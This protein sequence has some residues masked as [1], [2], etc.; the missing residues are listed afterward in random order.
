MANEMFGRVP[1][2]LRILPTIGSMESGTRIYRFSVLLLTFFAYALFHASRKPPSIVKNVLSS[3]GSLDSHMGLTTRS[4]AIWPLN[5]VYLRRVQSNFTEIEA[6]LSSGWAPF[7]GDSGTA[8]LADVDVAFLVSYSIGMY[9]AGHLGDRIDLRWFLSGGMVGSGIFVSLFGLAYWWN[10]H[11]IGY[12]FMVQI[13]GGFIQASGWPSVVTIVGNWFGKS[14]RGLIMGVWNS[15]TS[16]GNIWGTLMAS[17]VLKYGWGWSFLIPGFAIIGGGIVMFLFLVVDPKIVGLASPY[18]TK[19]GHASNEED[20][21]NGLLQMGSKDHQV[22]LLTEDMKLEDSEE[23]CETAVAFLEAW[24]IPG[25]ARFAICL[26]FTK[27]VAYTFLYWLP[28]YIKHTEIN[29]EYLSDSTS[30]NLSTVFDVGGTLGGIMAGYMS[31]KLNARATVAASFTYA[32]VPM[33]LLY[34]MYGGA[35]YWLN[36]LLLFLTGLCVNGPYA[37]ITTAV[38]AD[39]G[40]HNS[41]KGSSKALATVTAIIDGTGSIGAA[42]GPFVTGYISKSGWN[43]VFIM[44]IVS[45]TISGLLITGLVIEELKELFSQWRLSILWHKELS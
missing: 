24:T 23:D 29:G 5:I 13:L 22:P 25:V 45:A 12:F 31:D 15:H 34:R 3:D 37:L 33:L 9:F 19:Q 8:L 18:D 32:A 21:E 40:T 41:L 28:F 2:G 4:T 44:L 43:S 38:A 1:P 27:L 20:E 6:T 30:G 11:W 10:V 7:N 42:L 39:L 26:F 36:A 16:I 17:A 14:K 35:A